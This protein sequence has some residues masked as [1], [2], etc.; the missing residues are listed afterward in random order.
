MG[1]VGSDWSLGFYSGSIIPPLAVPLNSEKDPGWHSSHMSCPTA[2]CALP[3]GHSRQEVALETA[4][5]LPAAH[6][7]QVVAPLNSEKDPGKHAV[8]SLAKFCEKKPAGQVEQLVVSPWL[9]V[10]ALHGRHSVAPRSLLVWNLVLL[11]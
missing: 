11:A 9:K 7:E 6:E 4:A 5:N 1:R 10:P 2:P 3:A 8:H